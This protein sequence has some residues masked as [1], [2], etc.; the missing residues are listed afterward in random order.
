[1]LCEKCG[2]R[3]ATS[4]FKQTINGKTTVYHVCAQCAE[5]MGLNNLFHGF[6]FN[7]GDMFGGLLG[8]VSS[9]SAPSL[10]RKVCPECHSDLKSISETGRMG[11]A[12]CYTTFRNELLPTIEQLHGRVNHQGKLPRSAG[13]EA[14]KKAQLN[15]LKKKLEEAIRTQDFEHAAQYRDEINAIEKG[16]RDNGE[17]V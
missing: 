12:R 1:M 3:E 9:G 13:E 4:H 8:S 7:I 15:S 5:Q 11:C 6:H 16:M 14:R 10:E 17:M 2:Q